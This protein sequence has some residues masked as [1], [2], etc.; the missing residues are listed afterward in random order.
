MLTYRRGKE[1]EDESAFCSTI[2]SYIS[3]YGTVAHELDRANNQ[4]NGI[5]AERLSNEMTST[6]RERNKDIFELVQ[7]S[8][9]VVDSW[10]VAVAK[11]G[12]PTSSCPEKLWRCPSCVARE[13][14]GHRES[15]GGVWGMESA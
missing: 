3:A 13:T 5:T 1:T 8:N 12:S 6:Y 4:N 11:I 7:R 9:F 14:Y 2:A 15:I 10:S